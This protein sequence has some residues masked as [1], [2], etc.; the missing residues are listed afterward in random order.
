MYLMNYFYGS[1]ILNGLFLIILNVLPFS[2][3]IIIVT[4]FN[5][6]RL[7]I[8]KTN[9]KITLFNNKFN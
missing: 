1:F 2:K 8:K 3:N 9:R 5:F 6:V 4:L 7:F